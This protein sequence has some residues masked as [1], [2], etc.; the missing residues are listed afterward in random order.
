[1][2]AKKVK[3]LTGVLGAVFSHDLIFTLPHKV[4][5]LMKKADT[6]SRQPEP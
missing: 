4:G 3:L 6:L 5:T 2:T 1:M